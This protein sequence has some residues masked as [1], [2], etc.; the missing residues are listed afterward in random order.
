VESGRSLA[1]IPPSHRVVLYDCEWAGPLQR[2]IQDRGCAHPLASDLERY[3]SHRLMPTGRSFSS[4]PRSGRDD[5]RHRPDL[6]ATCYASMSAAVD[7][8]SRTACASRS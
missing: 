6:H 2:W 4:A 1:D 5:D 7:K 8:N 3:D